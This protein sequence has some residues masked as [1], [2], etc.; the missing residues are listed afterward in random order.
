[1]KFGPN[2]MRMLTGLIGLERD[3][4]S[5]PHLEDRSPCCYLLSW[6]PI[7][8]CQH[9]LLRRC[10]QGR[11]AQLWQR[12]GCCVFQ[13]YVWEAGRESHVGLRGPFCIRQCAVRHILTRPK[14]VFS[15]PSWET[16]LIGFCCI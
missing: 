14:Y 7:Y 10:I 2:V 6:H 5:C 9:R 13:K 3:E 4:K 11:N 1:M 15:T 8:V 16:I 12:C